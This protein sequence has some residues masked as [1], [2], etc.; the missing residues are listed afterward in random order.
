MNQAVNKKNQ[1]I[2]WLLSYQLA[3][4]VAST[5]AF[6]TNLA[7]YLFDIGIGPAPTTWVIV[8][9][10]ATIPLIIAFSA[11][12]KYLPINLIAWCALYLGFS[13]FSFL[14]SAQSEVIVQI[15]R[16]RFL[17]TAFLVIN[18]FLISSPNKNIEIWVRRAIFIVTI[19]SI[20]NIFNELIDPSMFGGLNESGRPAGFYGNP[21]TAA[22]AVILGLIFSI[23][24]LPLQFRLIFLAV[25]GL[26]VFLTFSR[27][28]L[29]G[30]LMITVFFIHRQIIP[31]RQSL[32]TILFLLGIVI[33]FGISSSL[34]VNQLSSNLN[35][36]DNALARLQFLLNPSLQ[37]VN[38][39]TSRLDIIPFA[40]SKFVESPILGHG[41]GY[42][43]I[44][45]QIRPHNM[46]LMLIVEHGFLGI[47]LLPLL[48]FLTT[49]NAR[50]EVKDI[51]SIFAVFIL[52]WGLFSH[53]V[54]EERNI[55]LMFSLMASMN[56]RSQLEQQK[57][58]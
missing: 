46:Y 36:D 3:L 13:A 19:I 24:I 11:R 56:W 52:M 54:F 58:I 30:W 45:G 33:A 9:G 43:E 38:D 7:T 27:G 47:T 34:L 37:P 29:I 12:C 41:I 55:L 49:V 31:R 32:Y 20:I 44:W 50:G 21:N 1:K 35:L 6:G 18:L 53:N 57:L 42:T 8:F 4:A 23:G 16:N 39:D 17:S 2:D 48:V 15:F 28:G 26:G 10:I 14:L 51:G 22:C 5:L 25:C 40:W